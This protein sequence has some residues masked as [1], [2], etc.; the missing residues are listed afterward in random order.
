MKSN[1]K[2][3]WRDLFHDFLVLLKY[4]IIITLLIAIGSLIGWASVIHNCPKW[5]SY[6]MMFFPLT[7]FLLMWGNSDTRKKFEEQQKEVRKWERWE[8]IKRGEMF[9]GGDIFSNR[10]N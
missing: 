9:K 3:D 1:G 2:P 6:V 8:E 10:Q 4:G 5:T 7:I